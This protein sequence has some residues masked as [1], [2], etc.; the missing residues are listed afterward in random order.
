MAIHDAEPY[1]I[2]RSPAQYRALLSLPKT[3]TL[4]PQDLLPP[5]VERVAA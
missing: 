1:R 5:A 4:L 3:G 2:A